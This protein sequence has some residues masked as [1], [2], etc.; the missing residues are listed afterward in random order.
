LKVVF[1]QWAFSY[2]SEPGILFFYLFKVY[3]LETIAGPP[4]IQPVLKHENQGV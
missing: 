2:N 1:V 3:S 4:A